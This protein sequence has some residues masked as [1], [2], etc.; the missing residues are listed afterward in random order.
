MTLGYIP[1][2]PDRIAA[3]LFPAGLPWLL[4]LGLRLGGDEGL[5]LVPPCLGVLALLATW[6][7]AAQLAGRLRLHAPAEVGLL[8]AAFLALSWRQTLYALAPS[9]DLAAQVFMTLAVAAALAAGRRGGLGWALAGSLAIALAYHVRH[10]SLL[11]APVCAAVVLSGDARRRRAWVQVAAGLAVLCAAV[12]P[13]LAYHLHRFGSILA[14]EDPGGGDL[15][16]STAAS[17]AWA[18]IRATTSARELGP[19]VIVVALACVAWARAR[20][21]DALAVAGAWPLLFLLAHAPLRLTALFDNAARF[22]EPAFPGLAIG[23]A[24]GIATALSSTPRSSAAAACLAALVWFG[25]VKAPVVLR[26]HNLRPAAYGL[27]TRD[28]RRAYEALAAHLPAG[29]IVIAAPDRLGAVQMYGKRWTLNPWWRRPQWFAALVA[30]AQRRGWTIYA[31]GDVRSLADLGEA[32]R[33][34]YLLDYE[35]TP[36]RVPALAGLGPLERLTAPAGPPVPA[37]ADPFA[38]TSGRGGR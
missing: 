24:L 10:P 22:V 12:L 26:T 23:A 7:A 25:A 17:S 35:W 14:L 2:G 34:A 38:Y 4:A 30:E 32:G 36:M 16:W 29:A 19:L 3:P 33:A 8:A 20:S 13:D 27:L 5:Y 9:S 1:R 28:Q 21:W 6:L 37:P 31:L 11:I 18:S 15:S